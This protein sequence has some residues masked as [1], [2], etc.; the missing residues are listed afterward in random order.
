MNESLRA[1]AF[2]FAVVILLLLATAIA[3]TWLVIGLSAAMLVVGLLVLPRMRA[4]G[5]IA[6]L[7]AACAA[8]GIAGV[9][10]LIA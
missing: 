2:T 1:T 10:S 9:L 4:R 5:A 3:E 7:I 8:A 6:A